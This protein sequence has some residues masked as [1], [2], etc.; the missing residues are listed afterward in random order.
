MWFDAARHR[1]AQHRE[2]RVA[3]LRRPEHARPGE[4]HRAVPHPL[5]ASPAEGERPGF[6]DVRHFSLLSTTREM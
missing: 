5:H 3:V 2:R 4:L 6:V 1:L